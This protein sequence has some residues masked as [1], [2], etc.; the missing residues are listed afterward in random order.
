MLR[1]TIGEE[2][3]WEGMRIFYQ[4][5]R[6]L[7]VMSS[8]FERIMEEVSGKNLDR[9]FIQWLYFKGQPELKITAGPSGEK[10]KTDIII[11]QKQNDLYSFPLELL[12]RSGQ[13]SV[14]KDLTINERVTRLAVKKL[15]VDEIIPD[16]DIN[17]LFR[18]V[19]N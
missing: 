16:P 12:I 15:K 6:G 17:L 3:F 8:D 18:P 19:S 9:F 14:K 4:K 10:G 2:K 11:E 13:D 5:Y 1:H 7:N